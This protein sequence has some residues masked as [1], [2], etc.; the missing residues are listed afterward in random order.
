[1]DKDGAAAA[2]NPRSRVVIELDNEIIQRILSRK[3]VGLAVLGDGDPLI[4]SAV[5]RLFAP[6]VIS[7]DASHRQVRSGPDLAIGA[8]PQSLQT[9]AA[10]WR[11]AVAFTFVGFD[12]AAAK[13]H[14]QSEGACNQQAAGRL[15]RSAADSELAQHSNN[16]FQAA[17]KIAISS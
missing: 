15:C 11:G 1:M 6:T 12:A 5:V 9:E 14:R 4:V 16:S 7:S 8:P 2:R 10:A 13:R 17:L 3:A